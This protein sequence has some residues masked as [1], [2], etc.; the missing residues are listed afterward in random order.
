MNHYDL[1]EKALKKT[2]IIRPRILPLLTFADT[3]LPYISLSE[4]AVNRGDTVVRK[5]EITVG[6]PSIILPPNLPQFEGFSSESSFGGENF[7]AD[8]F[9]MRGIRFP[10]LKYSNNAGTLDV[11][12]GSLENAIKAYS[13]Q[14]NKEE[15]TAA[16]LVAGPEDCWQFS[17]LILAASLMSRSA[18]SDVQKIL[19]E[20]RKKNLP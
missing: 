20:Y 6:R 10:S 8:F 3:V 16:G 9:L 7:F 4:S 1:W 14:L 11:H 2:E 15:N 12:E 5:G 19:E 18:E 17:L 13:E